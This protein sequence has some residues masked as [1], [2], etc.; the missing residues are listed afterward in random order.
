M[1]LGA[2]LYPVF[3]LKGILFPLV[4]Q[5]INLIASIVGVSIVHSARGRRPDA[6]AQQGLLRHFAAGAGRFCRGH[7]LH[8]AAPAG[9]CWAAASAASLLPSSLCASPS[10]TPRRASTRCR[11]SRRHRYTG[12]ATNIISGLA[13]GHGDAG[14]AGHRD[15]RGPAAELLLRHPRP[16]G[17]HDDFS[18]AKGIYGT[19]IATMGMLS[20]AAY[21][22]A[23][24]TFGPITDNAGG[25]IEMSRPAAQSSAKRPTSSTRQ[26]T[27]P[28]RSPRAMLSVPLRWRPSCSSPPIWSRS[29]TSSPAGRGGRRDS[30]RRLDLLKRE[31]RLCAGLRRR[32]AGRHADLSLLVAGHQGRWPRGAVCHPG[33]PQPVPRQSRDHGGNLASRTTAVACASSPAR[34]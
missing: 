3:G 1:I 22:L 33:C 7:L 6:R 14:A 27:R 26:A 13:V 20:S 24:D 29:T 18:Y 12:P 32:A 5:A 9:G 19:A 34:R 17:R 16:G 28:R 25:I 11:A 10:T 23:M 8:A 4:V 21:I 2:A 31:S 15:Q 30:A